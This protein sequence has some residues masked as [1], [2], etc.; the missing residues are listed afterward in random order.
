MKAAAR[1]VT[2][3]SEHESGTLTE[4][5]ATD[6]LRLTGNWS[7]ELRPVRGAG[8]SVCKWSDRTLLSCRWETPALH[9]LLHK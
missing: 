1:G 2:G 4:L 6:D 9:S 5:S 8:S 7:S 3:R